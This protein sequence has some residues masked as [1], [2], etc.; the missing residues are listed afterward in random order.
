MAAIREF[1]SNKIKRTFWPFT[2]KDKVDEN[3]N[4]VERGKRIIVRMPKKCVFEA[5]KQIQ[6][7]GEEADATAVYDIM[8]AILNNNMNRVH[9]EREVIE[10]YD[11]EECTAVFDAYMGFVDQLKADPN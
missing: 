6:A 3:G 10:D 11:V 5:I 7:D 1:N 9:V 4:V 8:D 2:L